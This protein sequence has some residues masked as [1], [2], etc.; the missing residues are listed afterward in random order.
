M[1]TRSPLRVP[2]SHGGSEPRSHQHEVGSPRSPGTW[3]WLFLLS[4]STLSLNCMGCKVAGLHFSFGLSHTHTPGICTPTFTHCCRGPGR[5]VQPLSITVLHKIRKNSDPRLQLAG[6]CLVSGV[7]TLE[8]VLSRNTLAVTPPE[9]HCRAGNSISEV[10]EGMLTRGVPR[11][12]GQM[13]CHPEGR[14]QVKDS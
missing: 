11:E 4:F 14:E 10:T 2:H 3:H 8:S 7:S 6:Y 12:R 5:A 13:A 1:S 9:A